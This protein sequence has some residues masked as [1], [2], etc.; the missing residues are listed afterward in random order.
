MARGK[1]L[2]LKEPRKKKG[3]LKRFTKEQLRA[4]AIVQS[5]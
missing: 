2:S 3:G 4:E 1:Y 5:L